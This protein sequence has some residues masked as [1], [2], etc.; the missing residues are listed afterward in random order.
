M[1]VVERNS[2][3]GLLAQLLPL[4]P[5]PRQRLKFAETGHW[6]AMTFALVFGGVGY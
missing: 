2:V 1:K 5:Y 3:A 6:P 4:A